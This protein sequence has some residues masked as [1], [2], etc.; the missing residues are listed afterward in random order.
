MNRSQSCWLV[1]DF[2][3]WV[4]S[5][6][7]DAVGILLGM[8]MDCRGK[9][10]YIATIG[11]LTKRDTLTQQGITQGT[12]ASFD[13]ELSFTK[14][15]TG[16]IRLFIDIIRHH[17]VNVSICFIHFSQIICQLKP[18]NEV[19]LCVKKR[20]DWCLEADITQIMAMSDQQKYQNIQLWI[21]VKNTCFYFLLLLYCKCFSYYIWNLL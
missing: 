10:E 11:H 19:F 15:K 20:W 1:V 12:S 18:A 4:V 6:W 17:C 5:N 3:V 8:L 16:H 7:V 14:S 13:R 9:A 2:V 21:D